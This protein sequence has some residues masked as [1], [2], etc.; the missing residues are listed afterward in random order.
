[1]L[2]VNL[3]LGVPKS[4]VNKDL[5]ALLD[6]VWITKG[7]GIVVWNLEKSRSYTTTSM[8]RRLLYRGHRIGGWNVFGKINS[9]WRSRCLCGWSVKTESSLGWRWREWTRKKILGV[10]HIRSWKMQTTFSS[11]V[12]CQNLFG[13]ALKMPWSGIEPRLTY[14]TSWGVGCRWAPKIITWKFFSFVIVLWVLRTMRN[15]MAIEGVFLNSL[16]NILY[17]I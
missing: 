2:T 9:Q 14:K 6:R 15:K 4:T 5:T 11:H 7:R 10:Q 1:M 16:T 8:Y 3:Y 17:K 12:P 13:G